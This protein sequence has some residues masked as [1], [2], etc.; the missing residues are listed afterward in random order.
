[1]TTYLA[2]SRIKEGCHGSLVFKCHGSP[3]PG[4]Y[5]RLFPPPSYGLLLLLPAPSFWWPR[6]SRQHR[7]RLFQA[8]TVAATAVSHKA[9]MTGRGHRQLNAVVSQVARG[10]CNRK[11]TKRRQ[12]L[13]KRFDDKRLSKEDPQGKREH[14]HGD[15]SPP[16]RRRRYISPDED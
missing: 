14:S 9:H 11:T 13:Q 10:R 2:H 12:R 15:T 16:R 4:V 3:V 6:S 1:M 5:A 8:Q 7:C